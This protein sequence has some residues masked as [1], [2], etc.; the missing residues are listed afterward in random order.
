MA[1]I[2][3][4]VMIHPATLYFR[5]Q[6]HKLAGSSQLKRPE[7]LHILEMQPTIIF[8]DSSNNMYRYKMSKK[9]CSSQYPWSRSEQ[10]ASF[11][12]PTHQNTKI[13]HK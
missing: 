9:K 5:P 3:S 8:I 1:T 7:T 6:R 4:K 12:H 11:V 2:L 13:S 10:L